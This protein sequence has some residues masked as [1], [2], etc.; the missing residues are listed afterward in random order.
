ML[1]RMRGRVTPPLLP[2]ALLAPAPAGD[3]MAVDTT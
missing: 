3:E 1:P 2:L